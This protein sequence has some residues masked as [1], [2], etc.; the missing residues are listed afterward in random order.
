[1]PQ[2]I[3]AVKDSLGEGV[4]QNLRTLTRNYQRLSVNFRFTEGRTKLDH[5]AHRDLE[6]LRH[7]RCDPK[8]P[9]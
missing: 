2:S 8:R 6:R 4:L 7:Q 5:K 9:C 1:M 3:Q